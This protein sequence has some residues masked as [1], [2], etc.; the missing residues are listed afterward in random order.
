[1]G[2]MNRFF[3]TA[4]IV[5]LFLI[6]GICYAEDS[7]EVGFAVKDTFTCVG[8]PI[9]LFWSFY[10][11]TPSIYESY[12]FLEPAETLV[13]R[14]NEVKECWR[15]KVYQAP[16][17][18]RIKIE[19]LDTTK[20]GEINLIVCVWKANAE[21]PQ[22]CFPICRVQTLRCQSTM[23]ICNG[24]KDEKFPFAPNTNPAI[25]CTTIVNTRKCE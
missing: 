22:S 19:T 4:G 13:C 25:F 11:D 8:V 2:Y 3:L 23:E 18:H 9:T 20:S 15:V 21:P 1:M 16:P 24:V 7:T 17:P 12:N 6:L 5:M 10:S 14:E